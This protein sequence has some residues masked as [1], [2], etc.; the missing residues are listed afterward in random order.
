M[1]AEWGAKGRAAA[2][3]SL[4]IDY[5]YMLS[6]GSFFA[7]AGFSVRDA[8]RRRGWL[9]LASLGAVIPFLAI[10][11]AVFDGTENVALLL[12]LAPSGCIRTHAGDLAWLYR[13][14]PV[15]APLR[16]I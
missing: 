12:T 3:L 16:V 4:W 11:A 14:V 2:R 13:H 8:A 5:G 9:R 6:Y 10:A 7:L 15:G 1:M